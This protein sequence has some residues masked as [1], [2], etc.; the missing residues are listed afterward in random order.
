MF[1]RR[2][3][4]SADDR[5]PRLAES[6]VEA[7]KD[8]A[9]VAFGADF[10]FPALD[11][12]VSLEQV[13]DASN[14]HGRRSISSSSQSKTTSTGIKVSLTQQMIPSRAAIKYGVMALQG[15]LAPQFSPALGPKFPERK[16]PEGGPA[17]ILTWVRKPPIPIKFGF[18]DR[19]E[20]M[21]AH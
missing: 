14:Y 9:V 1:S 18:S 5:K 21:G 20:R 11:Q 16:V 12:N 2:R 7:G 17:P 3:P 6:F 13:I 19:D 4:T 15:F 8:V 10:V